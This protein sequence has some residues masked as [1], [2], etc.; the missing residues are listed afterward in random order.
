MKLLLLEGVLGLKTGEGDE[1]FLSVRGLG[2][3]LNE[4]DEAKSRTG[5]CRGVELVMEVDTEDSVVLLF[6]EKYHLDLYCF[7]CRLDSSNSSCLFSD[8]K[9]DICSVS[10]SQSL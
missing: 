10:L 1:G 9:V 3:N 5:D 8:F 2:E 4:G 6:R 7:F